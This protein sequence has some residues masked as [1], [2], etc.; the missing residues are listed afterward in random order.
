MN[1]VIFNVQINIYIY[2]TSLILFV[3]IVIAKKE[4]I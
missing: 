4:R 2:E 3:L 1:I